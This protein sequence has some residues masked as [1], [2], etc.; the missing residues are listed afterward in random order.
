MALATV[1]TASAALSSKVQCLL[2]IPLQPNANLCAVANAGVN[3]AGG[4]DFWSS[5]SGSGATPGAAVLSST[6]TAGGSCSWS[7]VN[8]NCAIPE[9]W[10]YTDLPYAC[11]S[12]DVTA[13]AIGLGAIVAHANACDSS[14]SAQCDVCTLDLPV[15]VRPAWNLVVTGLRLIP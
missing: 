6:R 5:G 10:L 1:G 8:G 11:H 4:C 12:V 15:D 2:P 13:T 14:S 3:C 7:S 9:N